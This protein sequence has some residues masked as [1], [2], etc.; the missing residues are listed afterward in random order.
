MKNEI[1]D[2]L[3]DAV[4]ILKSDLTVTYCNEAAAHLTGSNIKQII[5]KKK[6]TDLIQF[7]SDDT[8]IFAELE[9]NKQHPYKEIQIKN[10][11]ETSFDVQISLQPYSKTEW[12]IYCRDVSL[13]TKLQKKYQISRQISSILNSLSQAFMI[14]DQSGLCLDVFSKSCLPILD[15]EPTGKYFWD[16]VKS[17]ELTPQTMKKWLETLFK[18]PLPFEDLTYL[19]PQSIHEKDDCYIELKYYPIRD[20]HNKIQSLVLVAE[21]LTELKRAQKSA[22]QEKNNAQMVMNIVRNKNEIPS[23]VRDSKRMITELSESLKQSQPD[24]EDISRWLHTLKGCASVFSITR[25]VNICQN[26]EDII[27]QLNQKIKEPHEGFAELQLQL[28]QIKYEFENF[29]LKASSVLG[30]HVIHG[31]STKEISLHQ[32]QIFY[33]K[34]QMQISPELR[35]EYIKTFIATPIEKYFN[36][37]NDMMYEIAESEGKKIKSLM[38]HN[39]DIPV[40]PDMYQNLFTSFVH[41]FRNAVAHGIET[42]EERKKA[43]KE[44]YGQIEVHCHIQNEEL[45]ILVKDDG[46]GID[47]SRLKTK[48]VEQKVDISHLSEDEILQTVFKNGLSTL[49]SANEI[50]GRGVGLDA[51]QLTVKKLGGEAWVRSQR[52]QGTELYVVV[53]YRLELKSS[54]GPWSRSA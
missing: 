27:Y 25:L 32:A 12:I 48:L 42:P 28:T 16:I 15:F 50:S 43:G 9:L 22:N 7:S 54:Q 17:S 44:E 6:L 33:E 4:F 19:G 40:L 2:T 13:E 23:F 11:K 21:D 53:P 41:A 45:H 52:G 36:H 51:L 34:L 18:E 20:K 14:F 10:K 5:G 1:F 26:S 24:L 31:E 8:K 37:Y 30:V 29:L 47:A 38:V 3:L 46:G 35:Q 39:G 49:D